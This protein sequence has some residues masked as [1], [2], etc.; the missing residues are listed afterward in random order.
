MLLLKR[1]TD[2]AGYA[3]AAYGGFPGAAGGYGFPG[4]LGGF[5]AGFF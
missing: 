1:R 3:G 2:A 5:G 4:A